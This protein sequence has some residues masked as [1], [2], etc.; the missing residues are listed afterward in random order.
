MCENLR[1][2][3]GVA[4]VLAMCR[5]PKSPHQL[6]YSGPCAGHYTG[7]LRSSKQNTATLLGAW[8]LMQRPMP[9]ALL[10]EGE[11]GGVVVSYLDILVFCAQRRVGER[12]LYSFGIS[13]G[14]DAAVHL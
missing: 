10:E 14:S 3:D 1:N 12:R 4:G 6:R 11:R 7:A 2:S 13:I 5:Q 9:I 8:A